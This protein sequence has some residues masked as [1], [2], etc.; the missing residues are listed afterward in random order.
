MNKISEGE[1]SVT[2]KEG[3]VEKL[4]QEIEEVLNGSLCAR[5]LRG[6]QGRAIFAEGQT[7]SRLSAPCVHS[8]SE[9]L[10][11]GPDKDRDRT[12]RWALYD[13]RDKLICSRP[14]VISLRD[15]NLPVLV[16]TDGACESDLVSV[17]AVIFPMDGGLP[18]YFGV[19]VPDT[20]WRRWTTKEGQKQVIGQAELI[21]VV[22]AKMTWASSLRNRR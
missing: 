8:I 9:W 3:R 14:R 11:M 2:N 16:F 22:L 20:I 1:I 18:Q 13:L 12:V 4:C 19:H 7:F 15:Q 10:R 5:S 21:P 17:G 6:I